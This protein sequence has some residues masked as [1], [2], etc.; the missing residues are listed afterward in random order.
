MEEDSRT[1][2]VKRYVNLE[3]IGRG[4][5][6]ELYSAFD[7]KTGQ[8][9][10]VKIVRQDTEKFETSTRRFAR[11]ALALKELS[12]PNIV[13]LYD[14]YEQQNVLYFTMEYIEGQTLRD[15]IINERLSISRAVSWMS[16]L[17]EAMTMAHEKGIIHRDIKPSNIMITKDQSPILLDFGLAKHREHTD[18]STITKTGQIVGTLVFLPPEVITGHEHDERGDVYQLAFTLYIAL[19][20]KYPLSLATI[21]SHISGLYNIIP[22]SKYRR[23]IDKELDEII[24][25]SL[26][27]K[28]ENRPPTAHAFKEK[29]DHWREL[30]TAKK[31]PP[32]LRTTRRHFPRLTGMSK[33]IALLATFTFFITF[34]WLGPFSHYAPQKKP[35]APKRSKRTRSST[36]TFTPSP[37]MLVNIPAKDYKRPVPTLLF[38]DEKKNIEKRSEPRT[39]R[40]TTS[41]GPKT[42]KG[43]RDFSLGQQAFASGEYKR[44]L[45]LYKKAAR[46]GHIEAAFA[47]GACYE[48]GL[49]ATQSDTLAARAYL[50]AAEEGNVAAQARI[51]KIYLEG[52]GVHPDPQLAMNWLR[53]AAANGHLESQYEL[54]QIYMKGIGIPKDEKQAFHWLQQAAARNHVAAMFELGCCYDEGRGVERN[55]LIGYQL[56]D[57]AANQGF[58]PAMRKLGRSFREQAARTPMQTAMVKAT[59]SA[60]TTSTNMTQNSP[61][62][63]EQ[64]EDAT[65]RALRL[66][67]EAME[68]LDHSQVM[69]NLKVAVRHMDPEA[70]HAMGQCYE[71]GIGTARDEKK[72]RQWYE[73][74]ASRGNAASQL[75]L[76][77]IYLEGKGVRPDYVTAE[78]WLYKAVK[79]EHIPAMLRLAG[80]LEHGKGVFYQDK[81][82]ALSLYKKAAA[83]GSSQAAKEVGRCYQRGI[84]ASSDRLEAERWFNKAKSMLD[85]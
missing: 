85:E 27:A 19:T 62:N 78:R 84:G 61:E 46:A 8:K 72:A 65:T 49:G 20:G 58:P 4:G 31:Q 55:S 54:A 79:R 68:R 29:L 23:D 32:I 1:Y 45:L 50:A 43:S 52:V 56:L 22:P 70:L 83:K 69:A 47:V 37:Q 75:A 53:M 64:R 10:A 39:S 77:E 28:K 33:S 59:K 24:L 17:A 16:R 26:S 73:K 48:N 35:N 63:Q 14:Y 38:V 25:S 21:A 81:L 51:S 42:D 12:H 30:R 36:R 5:M 67:R 82:T 41:I 34:F 40:T 18:L 7:Q 2:P 44:A 9:V 74:A 71:G 11:E 57:K 13:T 15:V 76:A 60:T 6:G 66:A 3:L 80:L